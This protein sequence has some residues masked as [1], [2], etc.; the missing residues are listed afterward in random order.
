MKMESEE[1]VAFDTVFLLSATSTLVQ[2]GDVSA[3]RSLQF[4]ATVDACKLKP[5]HERTDRLIV[6]GQ[7]SRESVAEISSEEKK[8]QGS[9]QAPSASSSSSGTAMQAEGANVC[10]GWMKG[11]CTSME[12]SRG[13]V[14]VH[15]P[16]QVL[17]MNND[18]ITSYE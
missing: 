3:I 14:F 16:K 7:G 4:G 9:S 17:F 12:C 1:A 11:E 5:V 18:V 8:Q 13:F 2:R 6:I 15:P 10:W